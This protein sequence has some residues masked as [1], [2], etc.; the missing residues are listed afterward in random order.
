MMPK[1]KFLLF[2]LLI[3]LVS[4][5]SIGWLSY[6]DSDNDTVPDYCDDCP[7]NTHLEIAK[8]VSS[9][10][11]PSDADKD[12]V[13]DYRDDCPD[14]TIFKIAGDETIYFSKVVVSHKV[15][16]VHLDSEEIAPPKLH[17]DSD[18]DGIP[19]QED[20]CPHNIPKELAN[21]IYE[22]GPKKGCPID[23]DKDG[24]P[25]YR[26]ICPDNTH[27]EIAKGV[28]SSGCPID[29]Y[30]D[31]VP[32]Y[33]D[34][35]PDN[36]YLEIATGVSSS[37]CPSD[38]DK[39]SVPDYRD[40]CPDNTR[41]EI[42][43]GVSSSGCPLDDLDNDGIP[44]QEDKCQNL[45]TQNKVHQ[46]GPKKGCPLD[47]DGDKVADYLD[48]CPHNTPLE[49]SK[50]VIDSQGCPLDTDQNGILDCTELKKGEHAIFCPAR[51][52][53]PALVHIDLDIEIEPALKQRRI[54]SDHDSIPNQEDKCPHNIPKE[55]ANGVYEDG[56]KK[57]C[58]IDNDEDGVP[59]YRDKCRYNIR[60]EIAKGVSSDGCPVDM[61]CL[62]ADGAKKD[63]PKDSDFDNVPDYRDAC[64]HNTSLEITQGVGPIGCPLDINQDGVV[65]SKDDLCHRW[66]GICLFW[67]RF[68]D[69]F[70]T[71]HD[72]ETARAQRLNSLVD[73]IQFIKMDLD[74]MTLQLKAL[75]ESDKHDENNPSVDELISL[76]ELIGVMER[77]LQDTQLAI[78]Q[79]NKKYD[80]Y[81]QMYRNIHNGNVPSIKEEE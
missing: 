54:D 9:S 31:S 18:N 40:D 72:I 64:P 42:A 35:C 20:R 39:D 28:S 60:L 62:S 69:R 53:M 79:T 78:V 48:H 3:V 75:E 17:I 32:D 51:H 22:D 77:D 19:N 30:D 4:A 6:Q 59:D 46:T 81:L 11:C 21:G 56:P 10:G 45:H 52:Y 74:D 12:S 80:A 49:V 37:G 26:D 50:G 66:E 68:S 8:G 65:N 41:L 38:A 47:S 25:D 23:N 43:M 34:D 1:K 71:E 63:C 57:G 15:A 73:L 29:A 5:L 44:N 2:R 36:T 61:K 7:H 27:L 58:P 33:R 70:K 76:K 55:L 14:N 67:D 24:V 13:P 16:A